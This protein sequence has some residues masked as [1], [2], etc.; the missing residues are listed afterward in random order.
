MVNKLCVHL[1]THNNNYMKKTKAYTIRVDLENLK[2]AE[3]TIDPS[4]LRLK[5]KNKINKYL[6][7]LNK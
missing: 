1:Y 3:K 7:G 6:K 5:I 4:E 2:L